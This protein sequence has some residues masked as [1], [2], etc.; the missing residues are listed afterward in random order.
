MNAV[1]VHARS[2]TKAESADVNSLSEWV[3]G[4]RSLV[5]FVAHSGNPNYSSTTFSES[6]VC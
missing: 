2:W 5:N 3:K 4:I 1:E 6:E